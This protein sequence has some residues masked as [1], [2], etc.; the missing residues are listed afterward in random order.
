MVDQ[1]E[2]RL[3]S[4]SELYAFAGRASFVEESVEILV[5]SVQDRIAGYPTIEGWESG[6]HVPFEAGLEGTNGNQ[7][8]KRVYPLNQPPVPLDWQIFRDID[9]DGIDYPFLD[10]NLIKYPEAISST[11]TAHYRIPGSFYTVASA[12]PMN[13]TME[14]LKDDGLY[15]STGDLSVI[16]KTMYEAIPEALTVEINFFNGGKGST[17]QYPATATDDETFIDS[18]VTEGCEWMTEMKNPFTGRPYASKSMCQSPG[19]SVPSRLR[20]PMESES[21]KRA[22]QYTSQQFEKYAN[23]TMDD[24]VDTFTAVPP[25]TLQRSKIAKVLNHLVSWR[26]PLIST[27]DNKSV[28]LTLSKAIFDRM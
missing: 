9:V 18:Y 4:S 20:N 11:K 12:P 6:K 15:Q 25:T 22:M 26:G 28:V 14:L 10:P 7:T 23:N 16:L 24:N 17:L 1:V 19:T 27:K 13:E 21:V 8:T 3:L 2:N 5:Q